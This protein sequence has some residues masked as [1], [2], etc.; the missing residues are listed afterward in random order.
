MSEEGIVIHHLVNRVLIRFAAV[1]LLGTGAV[2]T[3]MAAQPS[4]P[5]LA[6]QETD[7]FDRLRREGFDALYNMDYTAAHDR[8]E[9]LGQLAPRHPAA[10]LYQATTLWLE[11]LN[12]QRRLRSNLF[13]GNSFFAEAE[14]KVDPA[15]DK[16]LRAFANAAIGRSQQALAAHPNDT[17]ALYYQGMTHGLIASYEATV[18]RSFFS[19]LRNGLASVR[20]HEQVL[21]LDPDYV[22][23]RLTTGTYN[24]IMGSL[25]LYVKILAALGGY[26]G[27]RERGLEAIRTVAEHGRWANDDA[28]VALLTF[29]ARE[30]RYADALQTVSVLAQKYP[31]NYVFQ[32]ERAGLLIE[33]GRGAES[34]RIFE[35]LLD[36][37]SRLSV[38]DLVHYQYAEAL[39][40]QG[41]P[42]EALRH[43]VA[44]ATAPKAAAELEARATLR[45]GQMSDL[46]GRR[47]A[48]TRHY[49]RV[50]D[51]PNVYDS[52]E[53]A[54]R[55]L[56]QAYRN[57]N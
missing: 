19:A 42:D 8:F 41:Q 20:L 16:R 10:P 48:A 29:Y 36:N 46:L 5:R 1:V 44:A 37:P 3:L 14:E 18:T 50:L 31:Q 35:A 6:A 27:S 47:D 17:E 38:A 34:R 28:R 23:A 4:Q 45:A 40:A 2:P 43:F 12:R 24:Y 9:S 21:K 11:I 26:R 49:R 30:R 54:R 57:A 51:M 22:D 52:H 33:L 32:L 39:A 25:P 7:E 53:Q 15:I 55:G 56:K 13:S